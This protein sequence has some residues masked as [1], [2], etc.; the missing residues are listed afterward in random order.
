[1]N[2]QEH[3]FILKIPNNI[4]IEYYYSNGRSLNGIKRDEDIQRDKNNSLKEAILKN[5]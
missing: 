1:M 2:I 5:F 3:A 4:T